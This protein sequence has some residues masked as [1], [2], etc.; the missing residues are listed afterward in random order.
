MTL[1]LVAAG[2]ER[3]ISS[4]TY[5]EPAPVVESGPEPSKSYAVR[6]E[7]YTTTRAFYFAQDETPGYPSTVRLYTATVGNAPQVLSGSSGATNPAITFATN[8]RRRRRTKARV[9]R[10]K[11]LH[12]FACSTPDLRTE[13]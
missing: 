10:R 1:V 3:Q 2:S 13:Q 4:S 12:A 8:A 5:A 11:E 7:A 6:V 9:E